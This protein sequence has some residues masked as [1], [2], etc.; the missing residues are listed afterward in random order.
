GVVGQGFSSNA[1]E[2]LGSDPNDTF[3]LS[4]NPTDLSGRGVQ[5]QAN[6]AQ[7]TWSGFIQKVSIDGGKGNDTTTVNDLSG[8]TVQDV[9]LND[10]AALT[11]DGGNDVVNVEGSPTSHTITVATESA[12]LHPSS[13]G[14]AGGV[15]LVETTPQYRVHVAITNHADTLNV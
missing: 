15:M 7:I 1:L 12:F 9:G 2:I 11:P 3:T 14:Q 6:A 4:R 5:V 13:E 8:S 10:G